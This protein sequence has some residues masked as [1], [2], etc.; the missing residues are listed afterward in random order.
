[1]NTTAGKTAT[2]TETDTMGPIEVPADRY[3]GAQTQRSLIHF[4]IGEERMPRAVIW[5]FGIIKKASAIVNRD[6][7]L[8]PE[9][10][11]RL[12]I[13]A[14]DEVIAGKLDDH[15]PLRVWQTGSGTQT[16]MNV[17]EVIA[18]RAIE[19]A[20]GQLGSKKP[21]HPQRPRQHVAILERYFPDGDAHRGCGR[22]A[23]TFAAS[24]CDSYGKP[25]PLRLRS[26]PVSSK[27]AALTSWTRCR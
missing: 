5:A 7:G 13:Q 11:A 24:P 22:S 2:R 27:S 10:K 23:Q 12:I 19:L 1:M 15:F 4:A 17:N 3:W 14:A 18:N 16:N 21:I 9:D 6:L 8:L 26:S 20:G 25:W